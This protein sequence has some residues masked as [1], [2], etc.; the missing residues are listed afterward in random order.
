M[1]TTNGNAFL[2]KKKIMQI[3]IKLNKDGLKKKSIPEIYV[4]F[5][6]Y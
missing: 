6:K 2:M 4:L 5:L 3:R 1:Q